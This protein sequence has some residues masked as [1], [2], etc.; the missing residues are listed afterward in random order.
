MSKNNLFF[1]VLIFL[2]N[3]P[4]LRAKKSFYGVNIREVCRQRVAGIYLDVLDRA[5]KSQKY[6]D[7]LIVKNKTLNKRVKIT[8]EKLSNINKKISQNTYDTKLLDK[9]Q[10]N[11]WSLNSLNEAIKANKF[12]INKYE[13]DKKTNFKKE[14]ELYKNISKLFKFKKTK[15]VGHGYPFILSYKRSCQKY[16]DACSLNKNEVRYLKAIFVNQSVPGVCQE[17]IK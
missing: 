13:K 10:K 15:R 3:T 5:E 16:Y 2:I 4:L 1:L 6:Y 11:T 7:L 12:L 9:K 17:Y 14:K 8:K